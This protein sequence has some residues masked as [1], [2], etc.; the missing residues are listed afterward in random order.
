MENVVLV[1]HLILAL[2]L[3]G[4]VLIQRSEGGAL[5]IG[6]G[7]GGGGVVS[8]RGAATALQKATWALAAAFVVTSM[9]LTIF[10]VQRSSDSGVINTDGLGQEIP[11][12]PV[13]ASGD[14]LIPVLPPVEAPAAPTAP[15]GG[16]AE[17]PSAEEPAPATGAAPRLPSLG[18]GPGQ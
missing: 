5:G 2:L 17:T 7:G 1:I 16:G 8:G 6:G 15:T 12:G 10:A 11:S 18:G 4:A 9:T 14:A 3:V 13:D